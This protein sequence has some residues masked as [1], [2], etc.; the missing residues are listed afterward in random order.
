[1]PESVRREPESG[2]SPRCFTSRPVLRH[3]AAVA[4]Q[5]DA[6]RKRTNL[7]PETVGT[8]VGGLRRQR[9][10]PS[11]RRAG[12]VATQSRFVDIEAGV[13]EVEAGVGNMRRRAGVGG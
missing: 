4:V 7:L 10:A 9:V 8:L 2:A 3:V 6:R 13:G 1:M 5:G 11:P 12:S